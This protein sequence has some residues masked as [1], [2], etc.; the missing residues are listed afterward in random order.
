MGASRPPVDSLSICHYPF[1]W[2][3][4][5]ALSLPAPV[6]WPLSPFTSSDPLLSSLCPE[7]SMVIENVSLLEDMLPL[8][9]G[10]VIIRTHIYWTPTAKRPMIHTLHVFLMKPLTNLC[11]SFDEKEP[12]AQRGG[13]IYLQTHSEKEAGLRLEP[14]S[15]GLSWSLPSITATRLSESRGLLLKLSSPDEPFK[16]LLF[17][18]RVGMSEVYRNHVESCLQRACLEARRAALTQPTSHLTLR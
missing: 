4:E 6:S 11:S 13:V 14:R 12:G 9:W 2:F 1:P 17:H 3:P 10:A 15:G 8:K 5:P 7:T 18:C 16:Q